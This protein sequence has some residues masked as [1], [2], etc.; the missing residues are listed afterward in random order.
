M[1]FRRRGFALP[2]VLAVTGVVTLVFLVAITALASLTSEAA[3]AR[4]RV[5]FLQRALTAEATIAY[6]A[7]TEPTTPQGF[8]VGQARAIDDLTAPPPQL[9]P[10]A[11]DLIHLDGRLYSPDNDPHLG[12]RLRDQAGMINLAALDDTSTQRLAARLGIERSK[13]TRLHALKIDYSDVDSLRQTSGAEQGDYGGFLP[14]RPLLRPS[15]W[16][17]LL[18]VRKI[19]SP[20]R[21]RELRGE[22]AVD[23]T[24]PTLNV[25]TASPEALQIL[26]GLSLEQA[27][28]A[29]RSRRNAYFISIL[30]FDQATGALTLA[31]SEQSYTYLSGRVVY[32]IQDSQSP[33]VYRARLTMTPVGREQPIW[34]DQTELTEAPRRAVADISN[35][36]RFPYAPR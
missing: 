14:N 6:I 16:L 17:S 24:M 13:A 34:I 10:D 8:A 31:D 25:N 32:T 9:L 19:V 28:A 11:P 26:F 18:G 21:W 27:N 29:V 36:T 15:E 2:A 22:L 5:R 3:S 35:A 23:H 33:W 30:A 12:I 1:G 20:A 4:A 7:T